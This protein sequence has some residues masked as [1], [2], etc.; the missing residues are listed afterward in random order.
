[1]AKTETKLVILGIVAVLAIVILVFLFKIVM[2]GAVI[3][4]AP[5]YP[6]PNKPYANPDANAFPYN[7]KAMPMPTQAHSTEQGKCAVLAK[8]GIHKANPGY[9]LDADYQE[10]LAY[11]GRN[12]KCMFVEESNKGYCCTE[13]VY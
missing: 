11:T 7:A 5:Y 10:M 8:P 3:D 1:M 4:K 6:F 12:S 13:P 2:S 9:T